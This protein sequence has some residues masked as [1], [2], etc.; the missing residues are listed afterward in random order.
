MPRLHRRH[1]PSARKKQPLFLPLIA[2]YLV[3]VFVTLPFVNALH[4]WAEDWKQLESCIQCTG[5]AGR[6]IPIQQRHHSQSQC[7]TCQLIASS[8]KHAL[9]LAASP[10]LHLDL[11][12]LSV[13]TSNLQIWS[14]D[15]TREALARG[16]PSIA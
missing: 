8:Q 3:N 1:C 16:P 6:S 13:A 10:E 12:P 7:T 9:V 2:L 4:R 11:T 15:H 14:L 5:S